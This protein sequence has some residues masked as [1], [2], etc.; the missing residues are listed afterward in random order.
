MSNLPS[1]YDYAAGRRETAESILERMREYSDDSVRED[2]II[3]AD[4]FPL[5][6]EVER[7]VVIVL[8]TGGPHDELD[9]TLHS[10]GGVR[11]VT[12]R[13]MWGVER[14]ESQLSNIDP[15]Y[16]LAEYYAEMFAGDA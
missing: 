16:E 8:G 15:L 6:L 13:Y 14:Y 1:G 4:E 5:S 3:E 12:Y 11:S 9:A 7:H 2:A 10:D